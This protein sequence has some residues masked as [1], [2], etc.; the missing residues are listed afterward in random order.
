AGLAPDSITVRSQPLRPVIRA[1]RAED[2]S[3][4]QKAAKT[5]RSPDPIRWEKLHKVI[6]SVEEKA[7]LWT[8]VIF[9]LFRRARLRLGSF[10][11]E[12]SASA[13]RVLA[14]TSTALAEA[15]G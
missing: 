13:D 9:Y 1:R 8:E 3:N 2:H 11:R 7:H 15:R 5:P 14:R 12:L 4:N 10:S 6:S